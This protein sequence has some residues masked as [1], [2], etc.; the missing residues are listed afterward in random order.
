MRGTIIKRGQRWSVVIDLGRDPMSGKRIRKWHSGYESKKAAE[1]ARIEI[2]SRLQRGE[3]VAP[4]KQTLGSFMVDDWIPSV[5]AS[6]R[7]STWASYRRTSEL[8]VVP[9][10][11]SVQLQRLAP[12]QLNALYAQLLSEG[13]ADGH[14]GLSPRS[15]RYVHAVVHRALNDAVRWN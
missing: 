5:R 1:G 7:A 11:G 9:N 3:Y 2:L 12:G 8:H 13:R 15:V 14:G 6:V 10:L 4:G